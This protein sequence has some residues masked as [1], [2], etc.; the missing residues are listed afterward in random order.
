MT[1]PQT[2]RIRRVLA[3]YEQVAEQLRDL[4]TVGDLKPGS[5]LPSEL[6]LAREFSV[7]RTTVREALKMLAAQ[8][9]VRSAKGHSGGT[10]VTLPSID[11]ISEFMRSSVAILTQAESVTLEQLIEARAL[12]EVPAARLAAERNRPDFLERLADSLTTRVLDFPLDGQFSRNKDFH[13]VLV[14]GS[15]NVLLRI[16]A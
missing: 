5:R 11:N 4:I 13:A 10:F 8:N 1:E 15:G 12:I 7:S 3:A 14:E 2:P 9:L 6:E 16:A